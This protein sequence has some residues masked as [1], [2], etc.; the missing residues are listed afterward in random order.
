MKKFKHDTHTAWELRPWKAEKPGL[1]IIRNTGDK[2]TIFDRW[3]WRNFRFRVW[4]SKPRW[5]WLIRTPHFYLCRDN[6]GLEVG[7]PNLYFW[8]IR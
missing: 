7:H 2:M 8:W 1:V 4:R 3:N 6:G 5:H